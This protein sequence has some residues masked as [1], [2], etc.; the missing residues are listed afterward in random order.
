MTHAEYANA[1]RRIADWIETHPEVPLPYTAALDICGLKGK[2]GM[3][4]V[5]KAFGDCKKVHTESLFELVKDCGGIALCAVALR[6]NIC[7]RVVIRVETTPEHILPACTIPAHT[8]EI[9]EW[10]CP[11]SLLEEAPK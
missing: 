4:A 11:E 8:R 9:V 10:K 6:Q 7:E 5:A 3:A 2:E 1:L